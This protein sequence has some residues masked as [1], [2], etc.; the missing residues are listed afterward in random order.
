MPEERKQALREIGDFLGGTE[1]P[2]VV[3]RELEQISRQM[4]DSSSDPS[5]KIHT[6]LPKDVTAWFL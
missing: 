6:G 2:E 3:L 1:D 5:P 4:T